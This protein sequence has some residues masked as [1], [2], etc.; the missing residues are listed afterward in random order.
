LAKVAERDAA[1]A[2]QAA[3]KRFAG[4]ADPYRKQDEDAEVD[5]EDDGRAAD[6]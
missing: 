5:A 3:G 2:A 1:V 6:G 4:E